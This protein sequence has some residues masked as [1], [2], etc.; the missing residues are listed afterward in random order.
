MGGD[1]TQQQVIDAHVH[2]WTDDFEK[3][4]LAAGFSADD[5]W[6]PRFTPADH[7]G[8]AGTRMNLV[9]M[10]WC[11][12]DIMSHWRGVCPVCSYLLDKHIILKVS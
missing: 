12:Y 7:A 1:M 10:T 6:L 11:E 8:P 9:Q 5:L 4:P 2:V 3:Y